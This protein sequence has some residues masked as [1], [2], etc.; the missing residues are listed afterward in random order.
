MM[1]G[2]D[3]SGSTYTVP[4]GTALSAMRHW[5]VLTVCVVVPK[6]IMENDATRVSVFTVRRPPGA[7][8]EGDTEEMAGRAAL[9]R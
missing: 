4:S 5:S 2:S 1:P 8:S 6:R 9:N 7:A 3:G